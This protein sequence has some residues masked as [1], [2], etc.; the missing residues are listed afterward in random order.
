MRYVGERLGVPT[1]TIASLRTIYQ[2]Y[3]HAAR[4]LSDQL[5]AAGNAEAAGRGDGRSYAGIQKRMKQSGLGGVITHWFVAI[6]DKDTLP[7]LAF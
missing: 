2:R 4:R 3:P 1:P 6:A 7:F 5:D